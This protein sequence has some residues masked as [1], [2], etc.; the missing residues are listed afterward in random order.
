LCLRIRARIA[1]GPSGRL[2]RTHRL[3]IF[4]PRSKRFRSGRSS[5]DQK[6]RW[7]NDS[8]SQA[9]H[10]DSSPPL[11]R[12]SRRYTCG[13]RDHTR[14]IWFPW[15]TPDRS[16]A[17]REAFRLQGPQQMAHGMS[18]A[19]SGRWMPLRLEQEADVARWCPLVVSRRRPGARG[20]G[21]ATPK[22]MAM[23]MVKAA[24]RQ[25]E[26]RVRSL[27]HSARAI[28]RVVMV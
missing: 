25:V 7:R 13:F 10:L 22:P 20:P 27:V 3:S 11:S 24:V 9:F 6:A 16:P 18:T 28:L 12:S 26:G 19:G 17:Q 2:T 15:G 1:S 4:G 21:R 23:T 14:S 8:R 5:P